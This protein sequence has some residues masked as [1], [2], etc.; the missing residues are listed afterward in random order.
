MAFQKEWLELLGIT[1]KEQQ[2]TQRV[3]TN[4]GGKMKSDKT[5]TMQPTSKTQTEEETKRNKKIYALRFETVK[6]ARQYKNL[7]QAYGSGVVLK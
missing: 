7:G 6:Q 4:D 1:I 5:K 2:Y 3:Y